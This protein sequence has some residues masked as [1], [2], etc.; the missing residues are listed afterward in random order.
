MPNN[1]KLC[2][3]WNKNNVNA[4]AEKKQKTID[5]TGWSSQNVPKIEKKKKRKRLE[6]VED[7][8]DTRFQYQFAS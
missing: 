5:T 2:I 1:V 4:D 3:F 7:N 6:L 8:V